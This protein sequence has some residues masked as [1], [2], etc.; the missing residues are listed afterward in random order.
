MPTSE[1]IYYFSSKEE[2]NHCPPVIL[3]HGAGGDYLHWPHHI[4]RMPGYRVYALDLP[5]H[6]KSGGI[7]HQKVGEYAREVSELMSRIELYRAVIVGH[8]MGGAIAQTLAL[9]YPDR[10]IGLGLVGTGARL[11]VNPDLLEKLSM[12]T[13]F[14]AA[15]N[16]VMKWSYAPG[17]DE[18]HLTQVKRQLLSN[19]PAVMYGDYLACN[20]FDIMDIVKDIQVPV[21]IVCGED[22]K[23]TPPKFSEYL[24][25]A[26]PKSTL[27][28][29]PGAGHM[30]MLECPEV[31]AQ[32]LFAFFEE[33]PYP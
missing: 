17:M 21:C 24:H 12:E 22:D 30:V 5:G 25:N 29:I 28:L 31:L 16:M 7:G 15:V 3:I 2:S 11:R 23:M 1:H 20:R 4:R 14:P 9:E 18:D 8:S 27:T 32:T 33:L 19:R 13:T 10:V 6:G 26:I